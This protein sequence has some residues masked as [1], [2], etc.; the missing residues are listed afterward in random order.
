MTSH[1][2]IALADRI[3][4][5]SV[6]VYAMLIAALCG[7]IVM[8]EGVDVQLMAFVAP[9]LAADLGIEVASLGAV[10]SAGLVGLG[11]GMVVLAPLADRYGRRPLLLFSFGVAG[12][13]TL[14][15]AFANSIGELI[16][17]RIISGSGIGATV[18]IVLSLVSEIVPKRA[19]A[20]VL[21]A[22][23]CAAPFGA[24][25]G[26]LIVG[27]AIE[28]TGWRSMFMIAGALSLLIFLA[29]FAYAPE[30]PIFLARR[31][32]R[33]T[34]VARLLKRIDPAYDPQ[35]DDE[36][37]TPEQSSSRSGFVQLFTEKR[38]FGTSLLWIIFF[39][40]LLLLHFIKNWM[41]TIFSGAGHPLQEAITGVSLFNAGGILGGLGLAWLVDRY[42]A[43]RIL[44]GAFIGSAFV[45]A[46]LGAVVSGSTPMLL[47]FAFA[48]GAFV[49]GCQ[50][51]INAL[52]ASFYPARMRSTGLGWALGAG[53]AGAI[54]GAAV[55]GL[56][57][58]TGWAL[59]VVFAG[60][61]S[62]A[63]LAAACILI[64]ARANTDA[65]D[66][67]PAAQPASQ[68]H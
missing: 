28:Q 56:L 57:L 68:A 1:R 32:R 14:L 53:R 31:D 50:Y 2:T 18:P 48:S 29:A 66:A 26:G 59:P 21:T 33:S 20:T 13:F 45:A 40:N 19:R 51:C 65:P 22:L 55:G 67:A 47:G 10:F 41:P 62:A 25:V 38:F 36:F 54:S 34:A 4:G 44:T 63:L 52:A 16:A 8:I 46:G 27:A 6:G 60:A 61:G 30:S 9:R 12:V 49:Y 37:V 5:G 15:T 7:A 64:L 58:S 17:Y 11:L 35:P 43:T 3:D 39:T 23:S 42:G 24:A